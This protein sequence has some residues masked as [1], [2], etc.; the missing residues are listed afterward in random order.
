MSY[1]PSNPPPFSPVLLLGAALHAVPLAI[2][3]VLLADAMRQ[4]ERQWPRLFERLAAMNDARLL[5]DPVDLPV[6][7]ILQVQRGR[8]TLLAAGAG[9]GKPAPFSAAIRGSLA[10][11]MALLEG[12]LD[13]DALFFSRRLIVEGDTEAV[14]AL[15]NALE[16]TEVNVIDLAVR[17][18]APFG[19]PLRAAI[20]AVLKVHKAA[21]QALAVLEQSIQAPVLRRT[22]EQARN[23]AKL[24]ARVDRIERS[25]K[26]S[27]AARVATLQSDA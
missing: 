20:D 1:S 13:G 27:G 4:S 5:I 10:D 23:A 25:M 24:S 9:N 17:R 15:R 12:R 14:V 26:H 8:A 19:A 18:A 3:D 11:L 21:E 7:F 16:A 6:S 2:L 22:D